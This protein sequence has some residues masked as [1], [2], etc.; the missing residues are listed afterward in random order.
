MGEVSSKL[1]G[2]RVVD[3]VSSD[4]DCAPYGSRAFAVAGE[5]SSGM[6]ALELPPDPAA[7][8]LSKPAR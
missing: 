5:A 1:C 7:A 6:D 3:K 8:P 2:S 4:I